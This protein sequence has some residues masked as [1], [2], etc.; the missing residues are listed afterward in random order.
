M[1]AMQRESFFFP[2][3]FP[4]KIVKL[5]VKEGSNITIGQILFQFEPEEIPLCE[6]ESV[7]SQNSNGPSKHVVRANSAGML[8]KLH[9]NEGDVIK[10]G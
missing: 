3:N 8:E 7:D 10:Q 6:K 5:K 4:V 2:E 1:A 9:V